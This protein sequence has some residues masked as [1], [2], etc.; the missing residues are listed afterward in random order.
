MKIHYQQI[1]VAVVVFFIFIHLI[2]TELEAEYLTVFTASVESQCKFEER[3]CTKLF[4]VEIPPND[5]LLRFSRTY[6]FSECWPR[7][8]GQM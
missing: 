7:H 3:L 8:K 2:Y 1:I 4:S 6:T 5:L